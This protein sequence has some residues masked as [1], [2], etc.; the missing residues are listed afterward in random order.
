MHLLR[1][2][3]P[4]QFEYGWNTDVKTRP[5]LLSDL[6]EGISAG[7]FI[8]MSTDFFEECKSFVMGDPPQAAPG[9]HDDRIFAHAIANQARKQMRA[10]NAGGLRQLQGAVRF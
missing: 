10:P 5:T 6:R 1:Q 8:A 4:T 3:V 7:S 2:G 9:Q